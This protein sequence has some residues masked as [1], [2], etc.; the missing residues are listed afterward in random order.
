MRFRSL[1]LSDGL[2]PFGPSS[3]AV[4]VAV[5]FPFS[6]EWAPPFLSLVGGG[7]GC[8]PVHFI[9]Q[10]HFPFSAFV[11]GGCGCGSVLFFGSGVKTM[12]AVVVAVPFSF[13]GA[14]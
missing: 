7:C 14:V 8:G 3:V 12:V 13:S 4:A 2:P 10:M 11:G 5:P 1:F 6:F 9:F